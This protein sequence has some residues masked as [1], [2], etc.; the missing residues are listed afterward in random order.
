VDIL[1]MSFGCGLTVLT[2][3]SLVAARKQIGKVADEELGPEEEK[4]G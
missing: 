2:L 1:K 4:D 3:G